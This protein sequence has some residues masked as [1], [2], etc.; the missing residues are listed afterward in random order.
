MQ[1]LS[2]VLWYDDREERGGSV[3]AIQTHPNSVTRTYRFLLMPMYV[4]GVP[5]SVQLVHDV[6]RS[7]DSRVHLHLFGFGF[8]PD[9]RVLLEEWE[10][11]DSLGLATSV[12]IN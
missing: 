12:C 3:D 2:A 1:Y 8:G 7:A 4:H 9:Q 11:E 10:P 5:M 6:L